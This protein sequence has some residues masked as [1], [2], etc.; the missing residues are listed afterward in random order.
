MVSNGIPTDR[1]TMMPIRVPLLSE[2]HPLEE[3]RGVPESL[4]EEEEEPSLLA[5]LEVDDGDVGDVL[6][7]PVAIGPTLMVVVELGFPGAF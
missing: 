2:F 5:P 7:A 6:D 4:D 1:A 3:E